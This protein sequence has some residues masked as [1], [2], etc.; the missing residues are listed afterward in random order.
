MSRDRCDCFASDDNVTTGSA[1]ESDYQSTGFDKGHLCPAAD[2]NM[3]EQANRKSF[4]MSNRA[5]NCQA[6]T[7]VFGLTLNLGCVIRP[8][9]IVQF[10]L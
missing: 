4:L 2:N 6:S 1:A 5:H 9:F 8:N 10:M 3:S 7:G